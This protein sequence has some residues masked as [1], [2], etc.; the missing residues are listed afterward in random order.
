M[1]TKKISGQSY[2]VYPN[3]VMVPAC[4]V[5]ETPIKIRTPTDILPLL[6]SE[7]YLKQETVILFTLDGNNQVIKKHVISLGLANS[8]S[9]HPRET[10]APAIEDRA[11]SIFLAHNHPSGNLEPSEA[12]LVATRRMVEVSKIMG[13]P[14]LDHIIIS[15]NGFISLRERYPSYFL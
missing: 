10:F 11:V 5:N 7:K 14:I 3:G 12:D 13:I 9:I 4:L 2:I 8:S 6:E 1:K 15:Q